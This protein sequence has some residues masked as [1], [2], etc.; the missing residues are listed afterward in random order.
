MMIGFNGI[1]NDNGME[2][3]IRIYLDMA[4][5]FPYKTEICIDNTWTDAIINKETC[6]V[7]NVEY[8]YIIKQFQDEIIIAA[9]ET[10]NIFHFF[11]PCIYEPKFFVVTNKE[12]V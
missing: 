9:K 4:E 10:Q 8:Q 5:T 3:Y 11:C 12:E 2:K 1:L 7:Q 6:L